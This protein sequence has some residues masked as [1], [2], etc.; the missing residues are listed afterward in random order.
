MQEEF[1]TAQIVNANVSYSVPIEVEQQ[2]EKDLR[3]YL[4]NRKQWNIEKNIEE[5]LTIGG[6]FIDRLNFFMPHLSDKHKENLLVSGCSVGSELIIARNYGFKSA[7]GTEV[8]DEYVIIGKNRTKHIPNIQIDYYDGS[9]LPYKDGQFTCI[10]SGHIIEHT[11]SPYN[12][13][14]EHLRVL[15]KGGVFFIEFPDRYHPVELHTAT[16]SFEFLPWPLR[17]IALR[18]KFS[19][20]SK[21][22]PLE[23]ERYKAVLNTLS[24]ISIWQIK[25]F[26]LLS[27][28]F[29][30]K[31]IAVQRPAPGFTR[32]LIEK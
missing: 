8:V 5:L 21:S 15:A 16:R 20:Y 28:H 32:V 19:K 1:N 27:G 11:P 12:Y 3:T 7:T 18:Y 24:P 29:T 9:K 30:S 13:F 4:E 14:V 22:T 6:G 26:L 23:K 17:N 10:V 25:M 2:T 31:I